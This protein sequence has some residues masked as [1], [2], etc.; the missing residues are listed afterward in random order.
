MSFYDT[1]L[2]SSSRW[3]L[4]ASLQPAFAAFALLA[5]LLCPGLRGAPA[6]AQAVHVRGGL[7]NVYA[8]AETGGALRVAY[9][10]GSITAADGWRVLTTKRLKELFPKAQI[11]EIFAAI[12]GSGSDLGACRLE[13]DVL[14]RKPDLLFVEFAVN[15]GAYPTP[16]IQ[17]SMEGIVRQTWSRSPKAD[18]CFVYTLALNALP[19][20]QAGRFQRAASDMEAVA[21]HY[22]IPSV[23]FGPEVARQASAGSL[24]FKAPA[25]ETSP[26]GNDKEGRLVFTNDG[27]HPIARGHAIYASVLAGAFPRLW[28]AGQPGAHGLGAPLVSEPWEK[29]GLV[30]VDSLVRSGEWT[31]LSPDDPRLT[32]QPGRISPPTLVS[33]K[34]GASV[35][36][37][38]RGT[39]LGL[40][41]MKGPDCA[42]FEVVVDDGAPERDTLHDAYSVPGHYRLRSWFLQRALPEGEHRVTIRVAERGKSDKGGPFFYLSG[43]LI[44]GEPGALPKP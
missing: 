28:E 36:F 4:G 30:T 9:L 23:H 16:L 24:I 10:G 35:S 13:R 2:L 12:P 37:V 8:K 3:S 25:S 6:E 43:I 27:T 41:G 39:V 19:D 32:G 44:V 34:P 7:P 26:Q 31:L 22:G 21:E 1:G 38:F 20:L 40:V 15:D 17:R 33:D 42:P 18:I 11:E 5:L 29:A 14:S